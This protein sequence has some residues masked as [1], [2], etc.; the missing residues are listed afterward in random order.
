MARVKR[1]IIVKKR[2]KRVLNLAKGYRGGRSKLFRTAKEA[3]NRA[4]AYSFRDR[5]A[6]K[7]DFRKLWIIRINAALHGMDISYSKFIDG[8][9]KAGIKINR[10]ILAQMAMN[11]LPAF[12]EL[13]RRHSKPLTLTLLRM[14]RDPEEAKEQTEMANM[15]AANDDIKNGTL[16]NDCGVR[17]L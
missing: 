11:D 10:K 13:V 9:N 14:V 7:R 12:S 15:I 4:L 6:R 5:K 17:L 16:F 3:V 2:H 1:G 8:L